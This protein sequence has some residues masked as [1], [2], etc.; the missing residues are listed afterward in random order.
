MKR[1]LAALLATLAAPGATAAEM[2]SPGLPASSAQSLACRIVN[3]SKVNQ[4][5]T[6]QAVDGAGGIVTVVYNEVLKPGEAGGFS[7]PGSEASVHCRFIVS[8]AKSDFRA[9]IEV[10]ET[11][12][13]GNFRIVAALPAN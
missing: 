7:V 4:V 11:T 6:S 3:V 9:S 2:F 12:S 13:A 8:G 5:V 10:F 1:M